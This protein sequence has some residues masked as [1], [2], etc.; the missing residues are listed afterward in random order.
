MTTAD[1]SKLPLLPSGP[2]GVRKSAFHGPWHRKVVG[3]GRWLQAGNQDF[4]EA[5][6]GE[7]LALGSP[8]LPVGGSRV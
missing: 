1:G 7:Q 5:A 2:G 8:A 3:R 4:C 6:T